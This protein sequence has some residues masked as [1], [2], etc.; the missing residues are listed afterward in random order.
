MMPFLKKM[1]AD[2][3]LDINDIHPNAPMKENNFKDLREIFSDD[4]D[5]E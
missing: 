2:N 3:E 4:F 1:A 5:S